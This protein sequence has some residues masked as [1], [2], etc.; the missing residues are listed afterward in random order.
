MRRPVLLLLALAACEGRLTDPDAVADRLAERAAANYEGVRDFTVTGEGAIIY[1]RRMGPDSLFEFEGRAFTDD[2]LRQPIPL[3]YTLP[4]VM[5]LAHGLR[6]NARLAGTVEIEGGR[7]YVLEAD[8]AGVLIGAPSAGPG[9]DLDSIRVLVDAG[10]FQ[11][12]EIRLAAPQ[13]ALDPAADAAAPPL[14]QHQ[15]YS[16]F[17]TADGLTLPFQTN[18]LITGVFIPEEAR[19]VQ[20]GMLELQR[21]QA[22][23]LPP[24]E[25]ARALDEVE[26]Q[27]RLIRDGEM[28]ESFVVEAV[29][30]NAGVP[31]EAFAPPPPAPPPADSSAAAPSP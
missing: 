10:T 17:R 14:V 18:T 30:V 16:D 13:A 12:R 24:A 8:D 25:R 4:N 11:V 26:R 3:P 7:A 31:A 19:V 5:R 1:F 22:L 6:G 2:S 23:A 9:A 27:M 15:R 20:M 28:E 29:R 21:R